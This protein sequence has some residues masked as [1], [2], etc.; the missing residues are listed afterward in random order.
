MIALIGLPGS[1][2]STVGRQL[3]RRLQVPFYDSDSIIEERL[4]YSIREAFERDGEIFFRDLEESVLDE[5]SQIPQGVLSTGGG[6]ILRPTTRQRLRERGTVVYLNA[7][8]EKIFRRLQ[9]DTTRPLLQVANPMARLRDLFTARDPLYRDAA[10]FAIDTGRP[11]VSTLIN[12]IL[13]QLELCQTTPL[14]LPTS[15]SN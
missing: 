5:L 15:V 14:S 3:A 4:G 11:S 8:P 1:G 10:H 12:T 2:K 6:A 7:Q 9:N 13:M